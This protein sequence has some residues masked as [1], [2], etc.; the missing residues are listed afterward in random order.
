MLPSFTFILDF[1]RFLSSARH[2]GGLSKKARIALIVLV[3][4]G[5]IM[6]LVTY[7]GSVVK[8]LT[9]V[10]KY[11]DESLPFMTNDTRV[12]SLKQRLAA[13]EKQRLMIESQLTKRISDLNVENIQLKDKLNTS[14]ARVDLLNER[15]EACRAD[16]GMFTG[17]QVDGYN[18][19]DGG[20]VIE[21]DGNEILEQVRREREADTWLQLKRRL[22][23]D[24]Y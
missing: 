6:T 12:E 17:D 2:N 22:A 19:G 24:G 14:T 13:A 20:S 16:V 15:L 23:T 9:E 8:S 1:I 4:V 7:S 5:V 21:I 3:T 18:Y 11:I 10:D